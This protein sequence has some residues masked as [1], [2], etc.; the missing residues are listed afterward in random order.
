[1]KL[2]PNKTSI[3]SVDKVQNIPRIQKAALYC[4][5]AK[6]NIYLLVEALAKN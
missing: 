4:I 6:N 3:P 2:R 5:I 1:M